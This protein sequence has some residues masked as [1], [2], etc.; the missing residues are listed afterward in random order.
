V[1]LKDQRLWSLRHCADVLASSCVSSPGLRSVADMRGSTGEL[2]ARGVPLSFDKDDAA[3]LDFVTAAANLR[4]A[5]FDIAPQ[6]RFDV[7]GL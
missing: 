3:A 4:A 5:C 7:K 2:R 1:R 6:P